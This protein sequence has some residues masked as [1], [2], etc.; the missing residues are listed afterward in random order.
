MS[1]ERALNIPPVLI[2]LFAVLV[3]I[4]LI[5]ALLPP[6]LDASVLWTFGFVPA[7]YESSLAG[8]VL[9][10][11]GAGAKVWS[12]LTYAFLHA[13]LNHLVFNALWLLPF[14]SAVARRLG[15]L[16]FLAFFA[17]TAIVG[18]AA[19][20]AT[21]PHEPIPMIGASAAI[22]GAMAASIRFA[23]SSGGFA[24]FR[25]RPEEEPEPLEPLWHALRKPP[26]IA[27][28]VLWFGVNIVFG[29]GALSIDGR[30]QS[31]AWQAHIGGFLAGLLLFALFDPAP[32][33]P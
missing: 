18:A 13:D 23:F 8:V 25:R 22:S 28:L 3:G 15:A 24:A 27:F 21:H 16:R 9:F 30:A 19:H 17:V 31:I 12:F 26:V 4:H 10:S 6:D 1:R 20:L 7:R 5:R 33:R 29:M 2:G 32:K 14:G 11:G